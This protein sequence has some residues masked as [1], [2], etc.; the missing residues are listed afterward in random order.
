MQQLTQTDFAK[1]RPL[2][3]ALAHNLT[4]ESILQGLTPGQV[5]A[6]D[7]TAPETAVCWY[8][9]RLYLAGSASDPAV[10]EAFR[11]LFR[12]IYIPAAQAQDKRL[13]A[14]CHIR[15]AAMPPHPAHRLAA[16][17]AWSPLLSPAWAR[18]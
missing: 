1:V 7:V 6:D 12:D 9:H 3:A 10:Q 2:F 11:Q 16:Y 18:P 13:C 4:I 14:A 15:L 8:G 5:W 17:R